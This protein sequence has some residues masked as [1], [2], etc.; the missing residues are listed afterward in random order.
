MLDTGIMRSL[1][2]TFCSRLGKLSPVTFLAYFTLP[3]PFKIIDCIPP[4][5]QGTAYTSMLTILFLV[6]ASPIQRSPSRAYA[7][8]EIVCDLQ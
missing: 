6:M 8:H 5:L 4:L 2:V 7:F 3:D 1:N